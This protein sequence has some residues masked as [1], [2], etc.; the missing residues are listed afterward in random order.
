[1]QLLSGV[2]A[3]NGSGGWLLADA[4]TPTTCDI[5]AIATAAENAATARG[6]NLASY[7]GRVYVFSNNVPGCGWAGLAY[8]GWARSYIKQTSSLLVIGHE[9]GHNFGLLHAASLDCGTSVIGGT[10][11]SSEYGDPFNIMGN[12]RAMHFASAQKLDLL[13]R[14]PRHGRR[15]T[16]RD[17]RPT[18]SRRSR[19]P[20]ARTT[21][22]KHSR[23]DQS[24]VLDRV[25]PAHRLRRGLASFP[26]QRRAGARRRRR[27]SRSARAART[28]P[29][30]ST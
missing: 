21:R 16:R 10:C 5:N 24:H 13:D 30:S 25:S 19:P 11:T 14:C 29:S 22:C 18:R 26:E 17:A 12:Q 7:T 9:L 8:V 6:Y 15:R 20:A 1:M 23:R 28:T 4:P 3:D 2:V 27:S